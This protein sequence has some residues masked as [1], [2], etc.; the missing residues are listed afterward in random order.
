MVT[1]LAKIM[2]KDVFELFRVFAFLI[3][4]EER[5]ESKGTYFVI[6]LLMTHI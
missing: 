6:V 2:I 5:L 3:E 4:S 1:R